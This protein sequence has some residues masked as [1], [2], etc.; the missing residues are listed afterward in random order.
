MADGAPFIGVVTDLVVLPELVVVIGRVIPTV[1]LRA[2]LVSNRGGGGGRL[3]ASGARVAIVSCT[4]A[5][6]LVA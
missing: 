2:S 3:G 5:S 6:T 1:D 4:V